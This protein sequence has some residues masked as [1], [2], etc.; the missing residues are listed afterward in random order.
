MSLKRGASVDLGDHLR[1]AD[2][3]SPSQW[4]GCTA[5]MIQR[6]RWLGPTQFGRL[7]AIG[8]R[9]CGEALRWAL[10]LG[11][12]SIGLSACDTR[13][14]ERVSGGP[15]VYIDD[16]SDAEK[17]EARQK[18]ALSLSRGVGVYDIGIG[19]EVEIFFHINR[20]PTPKQYVIAA[21]DL[22]RI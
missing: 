11:L 18:I 12:L 8:S 19:D 14:Y 10:A 7:R 15:T 9:H 3:T 1:F 5:H 13:S 20:K 4:N 6:M 16:L 17:A 21:S 22:L 2:P